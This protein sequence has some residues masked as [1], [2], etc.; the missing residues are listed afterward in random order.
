MYKQKQN[1]NLRVN[2]TTYVYFFSERSTYVKTL[3]R[4]GFRS[5]CFIEVCR[6]YE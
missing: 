2:V 1:L 4:V 5:E 3:R 6:Y